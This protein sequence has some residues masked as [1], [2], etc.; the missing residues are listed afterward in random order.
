MRTPVLLL[1][2]FLLTSGCVRPFEEPAPPMLEV[3]RPDLQQVF[4]D[5][6]IILEL[7]PATPFRPITWVEINGHPLHLDP[8]TNHWIDTLRLKPGL[9]MLEVVA[10]DRGGNEG[11]DTLYAVYLSYRFTSFSAPALPKPRGGH[12]ITRLLSG[13]ILVTGGS[14]SMSS[15]AEGSAFLLPTGASSFIRLPFP[16][17]APRTD[18]TATLLPDGRVL[19]LGGS[20]HQTLRKPEDLVTLVELYTPQTRRFSRIPVVGPPPRRTQ[21]QTLLLTLKSGEV[22]LA[23][24]S[25]RGTTSFGQSITPLSDYRTFIFRNDTLF[26]DSPTP[27]FPF[28]LLE[29]HTL[30]PLNLASPGAPGDYLVAGTYFDADRSITNN[31]YLTISRQEGLSYEKLP[32]FF[33][34]RTEHAAA[35]VSRSFVLIIGGYAGDPGHLVF[36]GE[37]FFPLP[38][39]FFYFPDGSPSLRIPRW[40]HRATFWGVNR[41]LITGGFN[42]F[43]QGITLSEWFEILP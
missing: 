13:D 9:N 16:M 18:H 6:Y 25:G 7:Q 19:I 30:T 5:P 15:P 40:N 26:A 36:P 23:L 42:A 27:G 20:R 43:G 8:T 2:L 22:A 12:A 35:M 29:G 24:L 10:Y 21:H 17:E 32:P 1:G 28:E 39:R 41:I 37:V 34:P 4:L 14:F 3:V 31:L 11:K 38:R 33:H